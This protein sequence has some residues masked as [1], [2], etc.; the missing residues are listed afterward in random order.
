MKADLNGLQL[1]SVDP[2][3][4]VPRYIQAKQI[5]IGAIQEGALPRGSKLPST[6]DV[7]GKLG[8]S[9][10]T[11]HKA[12]Q[13]LVQEGWLNRERGR[14]T[15]VREDFEGSVAAKARFRV[16][17]VLDPLTPLGDYY[18]AP[19]LNGLREAASN[20][21]L[22]AELLLQHCRP[23]EIL[24]LRVDGVICFHPSLDVFEELERVHQ[25][26]PVVVLG[27]STRGTKLHCV[28]SANERGAREAVAHLVEIGHRDIAVVNGR[29]TAPN[30]VHR[31]RGFVAEMRDRGQ[32]VR[33]DWVINSPTAE[34]SEPIKSKL[35]SLLQRRDRPTAI[36]AAGYY[37]ALEVLEVAD[38]LGIRI[39]HDLS[40]VGFDDPKSASLLNPALSTV[41][42]PLEQ[43]G[44]VAMERMFEL[45]AGAPTGSPIQILP[46]ELIV[47]AS[48]APPAN[49]R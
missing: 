34:M 3:S 47:R 39:P 2:T 10:L 1:P 37:F 28:D 46:T 11:A 5:L 45:I 16:G 25:N 13:C 38:T 8:V 49:S 36:L 33:E 17:L 4:R 32:T 19:I 44:R 9:L 42:Q 12:I 40:L 31:F 24:N 27:G 18:H 41:R 6:H 7:S 43:M 35:R 30:S 14:G 48:T 29:L 26:T 20:S 15:F 22:G 21:E 23:D